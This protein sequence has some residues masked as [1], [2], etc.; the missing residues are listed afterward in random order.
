MQIHNKV[1]YYRFYYY[2]QNFAVN[3]YQIIELLHIIASYY[4]QTAFTHTPSLCDTIVILNNAKSKR[5]AGV[6]GRRRNMLSMLYQCVLA[7]FLYIT[8]NN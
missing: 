2:L 6:L 4:E 1:P 8:R 3:S 5:C 7:K